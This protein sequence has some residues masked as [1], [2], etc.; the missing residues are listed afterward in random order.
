MTTRLKNNKID[1]IKTLQNIQDELDISTEQLRQEIGLLGNNGFDNHESVEEIIS[2]NPVKAERKQ[3]RE[4]LEGHQ[5][6]LSISQI[7]ERY[8]EDVK[9]NTKKS[10][11]A[12]IAYMVE[13]GKGEILNIKTDR[14]NSLGK[15]KRYIHRKHLDKLLIEKESDE[16]EVEPSDSGSVAIEDRIKDLVDSMK[17]KYEEE[18]DE[19]KDEKEELKAKVEEQGEHIKDQESQIKELQ[20]RVK[21]LRDR[22][23]E[24]RSII[25]RVKSAFQDLGL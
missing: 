1:Y 3:I 7:W 2:E 19:L 4:Y 20:D 5:D 16:E 25:Q 13:N 14:E 21:S 6:F 8:G 18:I 11:S 23:K 17:E 12:G 22:L 9:Y 10:L 24:K 15:G